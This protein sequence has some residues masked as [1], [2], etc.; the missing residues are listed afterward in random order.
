MLKLEL[1]LVIPLAVVSE[2]IPGTNHF[3][4]T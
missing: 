1:E 4:D 3:Q 2:N